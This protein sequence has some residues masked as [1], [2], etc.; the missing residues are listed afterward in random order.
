MKIL[1]S[2]IILFKFNG[3]EVEKE[4]D[5]MVPIIPHNDYKS[6]YKFYKFDLFF[7]E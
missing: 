4:K 5:K 3:G 1:E 7:A 6:F 2:Q